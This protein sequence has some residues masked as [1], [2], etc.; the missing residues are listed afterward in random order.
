MNDVSNPGLFL[1]LVSSLPPDAR[2]DETNNCRKQA[3]GGFK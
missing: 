2:R 1:R 3:S